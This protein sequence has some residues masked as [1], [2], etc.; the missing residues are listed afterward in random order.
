MKGYAKKL[1]NDPYEMLPIFSYLST[2][3][4]SS[5]EK[6]LVSDS[7]KLMHSV[8]E[9]LQDRR[10]GYKGC[11]RSSIDKDM[12]KAWMLKMDMEH[13]L[14]GDAIPEYDAFKEIISYTMH[15][16]SDLKR[17]P[18][19][20][21]SR[22]F[23]DIVY[24]EN[25]QALPISY[26]SAGY[27]SLLWI[28]MDIAFRISLLNPHF[29]EEIRQ[30]PGIVLIDEIDM[31]LHPKWQWNVLRALREVFP[32]IQFIVATH[33]P[34]LI[35]SCKDEYL[36]HIDENHQVTYPATV[37]GYSVDDVIEFVQGSSRIP[38]KAKMLYNQFEDAIN[39]DDFPTARRILAEMIAEYGEDNSE[40][41]IAMTEL[42]M[43]DP[44]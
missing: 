33:S 42:S 1:A 31:H 32:N 30:T 15:I 13:Y 14:R 43:A 8:E 16:M 22:Q 34:I 3:R 7:S 41:K 40:V 25:D 39:A 29:G 26:L 11:L 27:Q 18:K 17:S 35:S 28:I 19:L 4:L 21:Y 38:Q 37:Y 23:R 2:S 9:K 5:P 6:L 12:I 44:C 20:Y 24:Q 10:S 36:I